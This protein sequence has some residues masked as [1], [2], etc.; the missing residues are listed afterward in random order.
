[1]ET[2]YATLIVF[3]FFFL[4][5]MIPLALVLAVGYFLHRLDAKWEAEAVAHRRQLA[6][7]S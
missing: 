2:I 6:S 3:G 5:L 4:R 1:M 7:R